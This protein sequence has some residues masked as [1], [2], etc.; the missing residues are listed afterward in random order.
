MGS[1]CN[2]DE[3]NEIEKY[4]DYSSQDIQEEDADR[5]VKRQRLSEKEVAHGDD[6]FSTVGYSDTDAYYWS[7]YDEFNRKVEA[8][9]PDDLQPFNSQG[10]T[11]AEVYCSAVLKKEDVTSCAD[12]CLPSTSSGSTLNTCPSG[13]TATVS[14]RP[15]TSDSDSE[16]EIL[17]VIPAPLNVN[18][19]AQPQVNVQEEVVDGDQ[20]PMGNND[21]P[22]NIA[23]H[24]QQPALQPLALNYDSDDV[25]I[26]HIQPAP[27]WS[28]IDSDELP[29]LMNASSDSDSMPPL[30]QN[31]LA[32]PH[33]ALNYD[34][35]MYGE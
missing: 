15:S 11:D 31:Q 5:S 10:T 13:P 22:I 28:D 34:D 4:S 7:D 24:V 29:D 3:I 1:K 27:G 23:P 25:Q 14:R 6:S 16:V 17:E 26:I 32:H 33:I 21:L 20:G 9:L 30:Y 8:T 12:E 2:F 18:E 35:M 19:F